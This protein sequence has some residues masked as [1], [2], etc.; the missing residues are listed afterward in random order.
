MVISFSF[1][2]QLGITMLNWFQ[3]PTILHSGVVR[4]YVGLRMP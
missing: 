4:V 3:A 2:L 1:V